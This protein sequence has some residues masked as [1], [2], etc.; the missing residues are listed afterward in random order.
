MQRSPI[1]LH[2]CFA[3]EGSVTYRTRGYASRGYPTYHDPY[4]GRHKEHRQYVSRRQRYGVDSHRQLRRIASE[5]YK[6]AP[7][8]GQTESNTQ[9]QTCH[10]T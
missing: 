2:I 4:G 8:L 9:Q 10:S 3:E 6:T 1:S 5:L 7:L